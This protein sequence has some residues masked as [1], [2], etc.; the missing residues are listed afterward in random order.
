MPRSLTSFAVARR[1]A[2]LASITSITAVALLAPLASGATGCSSSSAST[3]AITADDACK[4][5]A[6][7]Y[8]NK[9]TS[10]TTFYSLLAFGDAATCQSRFAAQCVSG[11]K[12]PGNG[13]TPDTTAACAAKAPGV[14]CVDLFADNLPAE[15]QPVAG[16]VA[17]GKACGDDSQCANKFCAFDDAKATCGTCAAPVAAEAACVN[18]DCPK[19]LK[20]GADTKC[21]KVGAL[22]DACDDNHACA[23]SLTCFNGKC[24]A[25]AV[26]GADCDPAG[27]TTTTHVPCDL[28]GGYWCNLTSKKCET[29]ALNAARDAT[30]GLNLTTG[31]L[32]VCE[33]KSYCSITDT[34]KFSGKCVA[35]IADGAACDAA[36]KTLGGPCTDPAKCIDGTCKLADPSVCK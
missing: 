23:P 6:T 18:G 19:G 9:L 33:P 31:G 2:S 25:P 20:C 13:S 10:C 32:T 34:M 27:S 17:D 22:N 28:V 15:C 8:C 29:I 26:T 7:A 5:L 11:L 21:H 30:C 14:A 24:V 35:R 36:A 4:Q 3:P 16:T 1:L 12:A